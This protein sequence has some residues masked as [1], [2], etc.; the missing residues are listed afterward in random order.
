MAP[1][2]AAGKTYST[3]VDVWAFGCFA[4]ELAKG[5]PPFSDRDES[6]MFD[7]VINDPVGRIPEKWSPAFADF[8]EKC[9]IRDPEERWSIQ[10]LLSHEFMQ[11]AEQ[12][13]EGWVRDYELY[14]AEKD[15]GQPAAEQSM[16]ENY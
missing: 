16:I 2:I 11:N 9:L 14:L 7:A 1:E 4:F 10:Q 8:V 15:D 6:E 12:A 3:K 5:D 13:R